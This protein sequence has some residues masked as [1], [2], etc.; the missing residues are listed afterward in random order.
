MSRSWEARGSELGEGEE[1]TV[2]PALFTGLFSKTPQYTPETTD[3][4][5]PYIYYVFSDTYNIPMIK[6][7]L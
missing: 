5:E 1:Y 2:V 4:C 6:F 3:S 7:N